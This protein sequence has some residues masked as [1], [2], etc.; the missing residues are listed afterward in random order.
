MN[1]KMYVTICGI[2]HYYGKTPFEVGGEIF[3]VK[4][5][6]NDFDSE[7]IAAALPYIGIIGY[8][9]NSKDT[10]YRGTMS[11]GRLYDK[12]KY[13]ACAKVLFVTHS[14][15]IAEI[16]QEKQKCNNREFY[17]NNYKNSNNRKNTKIGFKCSD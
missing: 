10:V 17:N 6:D 16:I 13:K 8:V 12:I 15:V 5:E 2:S 11:A 7:A 9:A 3:L 1:E 14:S 4:D